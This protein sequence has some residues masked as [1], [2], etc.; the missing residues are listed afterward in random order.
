MVC[1]RKGE[2]PYDL[3]KYEVDTLG[4][5]QFPSHIVDMAVRRSLKDDAARIA[6]RLGADTLSIGLE[7]LC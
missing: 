1:H 5:S 2:A 3:W 6:M 4:R 7:K